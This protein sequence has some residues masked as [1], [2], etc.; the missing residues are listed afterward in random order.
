MFKFFENNNKPR[1]TS[2]SDFIV[3]FNEIVKINGILINIYHQFK[4]NTNY[5]SLCKDYL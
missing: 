3:S 1:H 5:L 2:Q 4:N